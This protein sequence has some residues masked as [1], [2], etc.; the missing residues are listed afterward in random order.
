MIIAAGLAVAVAVVA[1]A[2]LRDPGGGSAAPG[3][4]EP[5]P[6]VSSSTGAS[7]TSVP[8]AA[9]Q[10]G[11]PTK[12]PP[13]TK[14]GT[15]SQPGTGETVSVKP[16]KTKEP[17]PLDKT[18]DFGTGLTVSLKDIKSVKGVAKAPG[19]IAGP[20]I[21]ITLE[22][23]NDSKKDISLDTVTVA[24]SYGKDRSPAVEL[25]DGRRPFSGKLGG[26]DSENGVYVYTVPTDER[27]D[28]RV[29]V[30]YTGEAPTVAFEGSVD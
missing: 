20:A 27:D 17:V 10:S 28:V 12:A 11:K 1:W 18:G 16:V 7:A 13:P 29:E 22:A 25:S 8:S 3:T 5:E 26:G 15:P 23:T 30:S 2:V 24:V 14:L 9:P 4:G 6:G 21:K 19:E